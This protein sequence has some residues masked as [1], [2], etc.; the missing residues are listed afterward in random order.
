MNGE[1]LRDEGLEKAGSGL[2]VASLVSWEN[3]AAFAIYRL[4]Q[5][6]SNFSAEDVRRDAGEPPH[7]NSIGSVFRKAYK[8]GIIEPAGVGV[9]TRPERHASLIRMWRRR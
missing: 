3:R 7:P 6:D 4:C 8:A 2:P 1:Q 5:A 9:A